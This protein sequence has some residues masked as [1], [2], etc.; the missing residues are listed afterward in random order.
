MIEVK[1]NA[2]ERTMELAGFSRHEAEFIV[3]QA[4]TVQRR[5]ELGRLVEEAGLVEQV[6]A[7]AGR[8][9]AA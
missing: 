6:R 3:E 2:V 5:A 1:A 7:L 4:R 8:M 9:A